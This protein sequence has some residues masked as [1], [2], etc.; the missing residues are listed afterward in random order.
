MRRI[1]LVTKDTQTLDRQANSGGGEGR[2][3]YIRA[4]PGYKAFSTKQ[5]R[6]TR[7]NMQNAL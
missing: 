5:M 2:R 6:K 7:E 3:M 1:K 4:H